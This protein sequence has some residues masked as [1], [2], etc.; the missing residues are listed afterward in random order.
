MLGTESDGR[1]LK[2]I[3]AAFNLPL[4]HE[5]FTP[6]NERVQWTLRSRA[7]RS[8]TALMIGGNLPTTSNFPQADFWKISEISLVR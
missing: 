3:G 4:R 7:N 8:A 5:G 2:C 1:R 6:R